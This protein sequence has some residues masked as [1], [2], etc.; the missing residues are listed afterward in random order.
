MDI[1][2]GI[3]D[4]QKALYKLL[5]EHANA[6]VETYKGQAHLIKPDEL[7]KHVPNNSLKYIWEKQ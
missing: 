1:S 7:Y 6:L 3:T 5:R 4:A 2:E